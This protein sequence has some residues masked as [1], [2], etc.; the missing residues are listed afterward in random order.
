MRERQEREEKERKEERKEEWG[1][2]ECNLG[3]R[4]GV[5]GG[6]GGEEGIWE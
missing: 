3:E 5:G 4:I 1:C 2:R 6:E